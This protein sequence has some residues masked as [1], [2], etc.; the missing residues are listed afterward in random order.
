M[1]KGNNGGTPQAEEVLDLPEVGQNGTGPKV[2]QAQIV[3]GQAEPFLGEEF[4]RLA[5]LVGQQ[6]YE[7][8][9]KREEL[10][11]MEQTVK[12]LGKDIESLR[13]E[14]ER[15]ARVKAKNQTAL[16]YVRSTLELIQGGQNGNK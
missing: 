12:D 13:A 5:S 11:D 1:T 3:Q 4:R 7:L 9:R 2:D 6:S 16:D 14:V 10:A 8:D 15:R